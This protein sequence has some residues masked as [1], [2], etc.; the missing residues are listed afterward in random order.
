MAEAYICDA[1][2]QAIT[3]PYS[4]RMKEFYIGKDFDEGFYL[5][6]IVKKRK[7]HLCDECYHSLRE[8]AKRR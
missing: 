7:V 6:N 1:C 2:E 4:V 3:D 8:I 5:S